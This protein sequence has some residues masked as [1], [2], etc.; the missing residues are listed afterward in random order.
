MSQAVK[1]F[2]DS[3]ITVK[4]QYTEKLNLVMEFTARK[5]WH[6]M[7]SG[8][9][10]LLEDKSFCKEFGRAFHDSILR[11][12]REYMNPFAYAR[13]VL[14]VGTSISDP[15][16]LVEFL[17]VNAVT[18]EYEAN[19]SI[20]CEEACVRI[21]RMQDRT[22]YEKAVA[23]IEAYLGKQER[24]SVANLLHMQYHRMRAAAE[25][26]EG[27]Y[28]AYYHSVFQY[29]A[30]CDAKV[31]LPA[32][33]VDIL[34]TRLATAAL[35]SSKVHNFGEFV[36]NS[37]ITGALKADNLTLFEILH[38]FNDGDVQ[39]FEAV[40]KSGALNGIEALAKNTEALRRKV[41]L[42][43]LLHLVFYTPVDKRIF[44]FTQIAERCSVPK[45]KVEIVLLKAFA[46]GLIKGG[47]DE[48]EE[49]V[50][51]TYI[52]PR[53]LHMAEIATFTQNLTKWSDQVTSTERGMTN[54]LQKLME[55]QVE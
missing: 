44:T 10:T 43:A 38:S 21:L 8:S 15:G 13:M 27:N 23:E 19:E 34:A 25:W 37:V 1:S 48:I 5:L 9:A 41:T 33:D 29:L 46:L 40:A 52:Q 22:L 53:V 16:A 12:N 35:C 14:L 55:S 36:T 17:T 4:P 50:N 32:V 47:M 2:I 28:D 45:E 20:R 3:V 42:M 18:P 6:E 11:T 51:V 49:T 24:L 26:L 30:Y 31:T 39:R 7:T 54:Y